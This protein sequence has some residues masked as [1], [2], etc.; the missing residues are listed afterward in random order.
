[1]EFAIIKGIGLGFFL[2]ISVGPIVFTILKL[3]MKFGHPVGYAYIAG[4]SISD[5]LMAIVANVAAEFVH[6]LLKYRVTIAVVGAILLLCLGLYS[7]LFGKDPVMDNSELAPEFRKRDMAKY[8]IQGFFMNILNPGPIFFWLT[9]A[10]AFA[11]LP[12]DER[13]VL[14]GTCLAVVLIT[15]FLKVRLAGSI[16]RWLTPAILHKIHYISAFILIGFALVIFGGLFL[17]N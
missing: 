6:S 13:I 16:R 2:A 15:D 3:S 5:V 12:L 8:S 17:S 4:V 10:T 7:L 1:M 14:F 11:Y 9:T